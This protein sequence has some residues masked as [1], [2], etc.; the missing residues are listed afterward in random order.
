NRN[1]SHFTAFIFR[2]VFF[3]LDISFCRLRMI[4]IFEALYIYIPL[5]GIN[6]NYAKSFIIFFATLN[7]ANYGIVSS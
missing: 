2:A 6:N 1:H 3:R 4:V 5:Y 7:M